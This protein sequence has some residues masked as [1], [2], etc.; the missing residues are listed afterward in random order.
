MLPGFSGVGVVPPWLAE[1]VAD[2]LAGVV[3]FGHNTPDLAETAR[4]TSALHHIRGNCLV[5]IDEEGGDVS[6]L[7]ARLGSSLPGA[8]AIGLAGSQEAGYQ[9]GRSLGRLLRGV[10]IDLDFAPVLDVASN[11]W[12]PVIG[13][14]SF[15]STPEAVVSAGGAF[16]RGLR[17]GGVATCGKHFP[18][19]GDTTT[20]SHLG[21]PRLDVN[22]KL[23]EQRDV[24][25]FMALADE[26]DC[27]M[28]AHLLVPAIG[29][30]PTSLE[31]AAYALARDCGLNGPLVT[32]ALDMAAISNG[33]DIGEVAVT[34]IEAGADLL[35]LGTTIGRDDHRLFMTAH[36]ALST[37]VRQGRISLERLG[38]SRSRINVLRENL[39]AR[40]ATLTP[41]GVVT[42]QAE[43]ARVGQQVCHRAMAAWLGPNLPAA[44]ARAALNA[45]GV[46][47]AGYPRLIDLRTVVDHAAGSVSPAMIRAVRR[48]WRDTPVI[49]DEEVDAPGSLL[50]AITRQPFPGTIE[51]DRLITLCRVRPDVVVLH[52]GRPDAFPFDALPDGGPTVIMACGT[53][54][55]NA[56]CAMA[57]LGTLLE[58]VSRTPTP[59]APHWMDLRHMS[60]RDCP[61][62]TPNEV[63]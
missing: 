5:A 46:D 6:R 50:L 63:A 3:L 26:L 34:A 9:A 51:L 10:G 25:P 16:T 62:F 61:A 44:E 8:W 53:G 20:D 59:I 57:A 40:R 18:G 31:P 12:N 33:R 55:V 29:P 39:A 43:L 47:R 41:V 24:A 21:L 35:C 60:G 48:V 42:A 1:V 38:S 36:D 13:P 30:A 4:L 14:R 58:V 37:A 19:H 23:L 28:M 52:T 2:G 27:V 7:E 45:A 11:P 54:R 49:R 15:G 17:D 22:A 56:A 32:D